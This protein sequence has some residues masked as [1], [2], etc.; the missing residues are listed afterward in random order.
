[1]T[2]L[3]GGGTAV[4]A[5]PSPAGV[6]VGLGGV[7]K[8]QLAAHYARALW[9]AADLDVLVWVTATTATAVVDAY[10]RAAE[11]LLGS[12]APDEPERA[13]A[14]FLAWLEPKA[15]QQQ[16]RWLVV[17]DDVVDPAGMT[18][19]WPPA[20]PTGRTLVTTRRQDPALTAGRA[21]VTVGVYTPDESRTYLADMLAGHGLTEAPEALDG[22][23]QDL[24]H[25]P[26]ALA[27]AAAY[28]AELADIGMTVTAY[29]RL[30]A[31]RTTALKDT[32]PNLLP[33]QQ[34]RTVAATWTLSVEHASTLRPVGLARPMLHL[35][36]HLDPNGIP[37][38]VLTSVPAR[39]HLAQYADIVGGE[40]SDR[41]QR[42]GLIARFLR[43]RAKPAPIPPVSEDAARAA[44]SALR[45]LSLIEYTAGT[46]HAAVRT[47]Q[48]VQRA[49][50][51]TLTPDQ[52]H[53]AARAAA[54][55]LMAAWPRIERNTALIQALR[56]NTG[57]LAACAE[58]A[59]YLFHV[60][61]VLARTGDSLA[62]AGQVEAACAHFRHVAELAHKRLGSDHPD[63]LAARG[64]LAS[65]QGAAGDPAGAA[66]AF[67]DLLADQMRVLGP[68]DP[69]TLTI[70]NDL[71]HWLGA[72]GDA[73]GA[74]EAL[75]DLLTDQMRVLGPD[76]PH[77][78]TTRGNLASWRGE[79]G[80]AAGAAEALADQLSDRARVLG[81]DHPDT[82]AT[83]NNLASWLGEAGDAAGA[84]E[85]LADLLTE[86]TRVLGPDHPHTLTTRG[87]LASWVGE[88]G[89]AAGAAKALAD[90]LPECTRVLGPDHPN[91]L[92]TRNNLASWRGGAG[93]A[94]GA[95]AE[96]ADLLTDQMRV[97]GP[98]HPDTLATRSNL[99]HW[100]GKAG[101][102]AG[103][104]A[105]FAD[106]LA[107]QM[108]VLGLDH[109]D[110]LTTRNN[111]ASW[112]G[113]AGNPAGAAAAL[114]D[115][116]PECTRVLGPNHPH[117]LTIHNNLAHWQKSA[118][119]E[120]NRAPKPDN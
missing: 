47:H 30:F 109:P 48:L 23:A 102:A 103:A 6:V 5:Q 24:G 95:V 113:E 90:L 14:A 64:S 35:A 77:T 54:D 71:A 45:R 61:A 21:L 16:C 28:I 76:H 70:R 15:A 19:L 4:V 18:G 118:S 111:L 74:A 22:L 92:T 101:D 84:A 79:A 60:H 66:A 110:I 11:E 13:A 78:L 88:A 20:S 10:A 115:L 56:A 99:S 27:Q 80:D 86:C 82:L 8:S 75:A 65:W 39:S 106:L 81:S 37:D 26:L 49:V 3:S 63:T 43:R 36:A 57:S 62:E 58:N 59:L 25:L 69:N 73:A 85:A 120:G 96:F 105:E 117:T 100:R 55:A 51:D 17:L 87:N 91:T 2:A 44:L 38:V 107:G 119:P 52:H 42:H 83:R 68:D 9:Q 89:D 97:L 46:P 40:N 53:Q 67:A 108:R 112:L 94:A 93:D 98:D 50:R 72:A 33:D 31:D 116:L 41:E 32:A 104:V 114:A 1:M 34:S 12:S 29:R 7:G